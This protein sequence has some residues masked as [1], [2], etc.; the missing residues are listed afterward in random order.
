LQSQIGF[1]T[2]AE[3]R[4]RT[5]IAVL[6]ELQIS[7]AE[8]DFAVGGNGFRDLFQLLRLVRNNSCAVLVG[9]IP[10][11]VSMRLFLCLA[12]IAPAL[13]AEIYFRRFALALSNSRVTRRV[14]G[15][16]ERGCFVPPP[17]SV[18]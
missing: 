8:I 10:A 14:F 17:S 4:D 3:V 2:N 11:H 6:A 7:R 1:H 13:V 12:F 5:T 18:C 16:V 15:V 9:T